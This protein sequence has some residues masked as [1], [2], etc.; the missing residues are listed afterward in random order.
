MIHLILGV[1]WHNLLTV[2]PG[3]S[4]AINYLRSIGKRVIF[5]TNNSIISTED[6]LRKFANCNIHVDEVNTYIFATS[7]KVRRFTSY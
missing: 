3:A 5:V 4:D 6:Q 1:I 7:T 2:I